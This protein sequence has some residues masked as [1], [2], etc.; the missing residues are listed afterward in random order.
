METTQKRGHVRVLIAAAIL[1]A[2]LATVAPSFDFDSDGDG[3]ADVTEINNLGT[4]PS[5]ADTFGR[6]VLSERANTK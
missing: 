6:P 5:K 2:G 1:V 3:V 4:D